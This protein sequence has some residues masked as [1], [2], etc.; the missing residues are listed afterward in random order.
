MFILNSGA[1]TEIF[2]RY[3]MGS[4]LILLQRMNITAIQ[5]KAI[6]DEIGKVKLVLSVQ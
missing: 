1:W 5:A 4:L 3:I 6:G 2:Y